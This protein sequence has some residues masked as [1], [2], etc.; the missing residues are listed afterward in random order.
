MG[1]ASWLPCV[2]ERYGL[3]IEKLRR[4]ERKNQGTTDLTALLWLKGLGQSW[5]ACP[6]EE[7]N[8]GQDIDDNDVSILHPDYCIIYWYC[9]YIYIHTIVSRFDGLN[10]QLVLKSVWALCEASCQWRYRHSGWGVDEF[11]WILQR[12]IQG[13]SNG[14]FRN[15]KWRY[16]PYIRPI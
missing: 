9:I 7:L 11:R 3:R 12:Q 8:A 15:L 6:C 14:H 1:V 2:W 13:F 16:L 10:P 5:P 4:G